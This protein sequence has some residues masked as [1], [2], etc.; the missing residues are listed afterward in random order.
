MG[1]RSRLKRLEG[2]VGKHRWVLVC[3]ECGVERVLRG[4][5]PMEYLVAEWSIQSGQAD[6][7]PEDV[8]ALMAHEHDP[9]AFLDKASGLPFLSREVNGIGFYQNGL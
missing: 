4:D 2:E 7:I 6:D 5:A 9:G 3:P 1:I 8:A